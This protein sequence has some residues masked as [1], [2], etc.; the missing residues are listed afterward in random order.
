MNLLELLILTV[1]IWLLLRLFSA[2]GRSRGGEQ[3]GTNVGTSGS[4]E[5]IT[6]ETCGGYGCGNCNGAGFT[7]K[8]GTPMH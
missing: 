7:D 8:W 5:R 1:G 2:I 4:Y 3:S 6:C